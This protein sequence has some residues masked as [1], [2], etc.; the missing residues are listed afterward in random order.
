MGRPRFSGGKFPRAYLPK[1]TRAWIGA[2]THILESQWRDAPLAGPVAVEIV[3]VH[4]RPK[5]LCRRKDP[6]GRIWRGVRPDIDNLVKCALD[7]LQGAGIITDDG[8]V[9][10][11]VALDQYARKDEDSKVTI[12]VINVDEI[13]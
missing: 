11:L 13:G 9:V 10:A 6:A 12:A 3:F 4:S 8:Q 2:A 1:K 5:R 7:A